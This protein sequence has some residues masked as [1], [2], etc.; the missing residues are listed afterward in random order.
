MR[1][2]NSADIG[3]RGHFDG[4]LKMMT[5]PWKPCLASTGKGAARETSTAEFNVGWRVF[6]SIRG[7]FSEWSICRRISLPV[8][9]I[10]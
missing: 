6:L 4:R 2:K 9:L 8:R 3:P 1:N 10:G 7:L 5:R